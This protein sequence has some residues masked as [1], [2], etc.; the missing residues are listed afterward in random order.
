MLRG[1][2]DIANTQKMLSIMTLLSVVKVKTV[3]INS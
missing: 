2:W 1:R 3:Q